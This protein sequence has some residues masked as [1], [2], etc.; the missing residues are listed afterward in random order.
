MEN[1]HQYSSSST[2]YRFFKPSDTKNCLKRT[3]FLL[4]AFIYHTE[5]YDL[6]NRRYRTCIFTT[7]AWFDIF[8]HLAIYIELRVKYSTYRILLGPFLSSFYVLN[9]LHR[10]PIKPGSF[11]RIIFD[12]RVTGTVPHL[13]RRPCLILTQFSK[14]VRFFPLH[15]R[16]LYEFN[17]K[18]GVSYTQIHLSSYF[19]KQNRPVCLPIQRIWPPD[20]S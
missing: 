1:L 14:N 7:S 4:Q 5:T 15:P 6:R 3:D 16:W 8:L 12:H 9:K 10:L 18:I 13:L 2:T 11:L 19:F 20:L 17:F